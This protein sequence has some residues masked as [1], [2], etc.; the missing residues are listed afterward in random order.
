[1]NLPIIWSPQSEIEY[2]NILNYLNDEWGGQTVKIVVHNVEKI[3]D[4]IARMPYLF[5]GLK[6]RKKI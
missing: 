6:Q 3:L 1:M 2:V 5:P 4:Q